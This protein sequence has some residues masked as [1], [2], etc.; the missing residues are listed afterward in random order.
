MSDKESLNLRVEEGLKDEV[1]KIAEDVEG[2]SRSSDLSSTAQKLIVIGIGAE[3]AGVQEKAEVVGPLGIVP[4]PFATMEFEGDKISMGTQLTA[5]Q[6]DDLQSVFEAK[7]HTAAREALRLGV[8]LVQADDLD[9][10]FE[11][12]LGI[13]R[14]LARMQVEEKV[15]GDHAFEALETIKEARDE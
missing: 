5:E 11:G 13:F 10:R 15:E 12:P 14:P 2:D 8:I 1:S 9:A 4:R 7:K 3:R 6:L